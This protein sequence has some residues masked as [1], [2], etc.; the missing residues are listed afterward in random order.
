MQEYIQL[1]IATSVFFADAGIAMHQWFILSLLYWIFVTL[2]CYWVSITLNLL[3]SA[4]VSSE[5][6]SGLSEGPVLGLW[7]N[8]CF[9]S[10]GASELR[11][12]SLIL[13]HTWSE[14]ETESCLSWASGLDTFTQAKH[15][16]FLQITT[17]HHMETWIQFTG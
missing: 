11:F 4:L 3:F 7:R 14:P 17:S 8:Q 9:A 6:L 5:Q 10:G 2:S 13:R 1:C 12:A 16:L 15:F